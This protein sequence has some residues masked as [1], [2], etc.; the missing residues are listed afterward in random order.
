MDQE[1]HTPSYGLDVPKFEKEAITRIEM[2]PGLLRMNQR[3]GLAGLNSGENAD[4]VFVSV[5]VHLKLIDIMMQ[6]YLQ[7]L[8]ISNQ[9]IK[10]I[11]SS[12][13][14]VKCS[15]NKMNEYLIRPT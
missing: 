13:I 7:D 10:R 3:L 4:N 5:E 9:K 8:E 2:P 1:V 12:Y 6:M 11:E 14:D 15:E